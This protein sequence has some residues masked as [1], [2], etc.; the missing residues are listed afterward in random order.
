MPHLNRRPS[1]RFGHKLALRVQKPES[2]TA[3]PPKI[4]DLV[5]PRLSGQSSGYLMSIHMCR[6]FARV[7]Y[8][9]CFLAK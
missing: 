1:P 3:K 5:T 6:N 9:L 4:V 7:A 2:V 8:K